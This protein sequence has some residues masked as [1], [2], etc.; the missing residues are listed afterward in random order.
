MLEPH[1]RT[2]AYLIRRAAAGGCEA[3]NHTPFREVVVGGGCTS[4]RK[5]SNGPEQ[6]RTR[7]EGVESERK[8]SLR[9]L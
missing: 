3:Y 4:Q 5:A 8:S 7:G 1:H 2:T 9:G 6:V